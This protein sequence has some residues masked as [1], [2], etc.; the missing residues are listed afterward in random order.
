MFET[1]I[2]DDKSEKF[3]LNMLESDFKKFNYIV[4]NNPGLTTKKYLNLMNFDNFTEEKLEYA[5]RLFNTNKSSF[6]NICG[7][8]LFDNKNKTWYL[9]NIRRSRNNI[10]VDSLIKDA[11]YAQHRSTNFSTAI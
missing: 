10:N 1:P 8:F 6:H 3:S 2:L 5:F 4:K 11:T 7:P 9:D